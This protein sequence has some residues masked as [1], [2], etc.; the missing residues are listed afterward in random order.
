MAILTG[1]CKWVLQSGDAAYAMAVTDDGL[2]VHSHWGRCLPRLE[3]YPTPV[4]QPPFPCE[5]PFQLTPQELP[6]GE[7]SASDERGI[8][9]MTADGRI[10]GLILRFTDAA[11]AGDTLTITLTDTA[12]HLRV[13]LTYAVLDQPGLFSRSVAVIN[14]GDR[15]FKITRLF[16]G[17]FNLPDTG[18]F[19]ITQL[20]GR[21]GD[22]FR[23]QRDPLP[24][25]T[26][27]RDSRRIITSHGGVPYFALDRVAPGLAASEETGALWFGTLDWSGNW[28]LI[29]ERTRDDRAIVHLGL[30]DH[31]FA[32]D[33]QPGERFDAPRIVFGYTEGGFGAMSRSF[34]DLIRDT[35]APRKP[36]VPPVVYNSWYATT[37]HVDEAGQTALADKAAAMGVEMFVMDD[38][39]F[40]GRVDDTAGLGDWWPD[41]V[42]FP[43]GLGPLIAAVKA[44]GMGFGLWIEPEMV[45]PNS[46]LYAAHPDW[47][48]HFPGRDRTQM[49]NQLLLNLG[50]ADVQAYLIGIFDRLLTENAIDFVKWDMNR[51]ASEPGWPDHSRDQR[52]IWVRYVQGLRRVWQTLRDRHPRVI[53]ENCSSG[54]GRV[55][56]AMMGITEQSWASDNTFVPARLLIQEGYSQ[57]FP[58][59]TMAAWVTDSGDYSLDLRFHT[60][61]AGAL[62]VGGN[63]LRWSDAD[64]A[65]AAEHVARYKLLRGVIAQGDLYRIRSAHAYTVSAFAYVAKD[66]SEAVLFAFRMH[67]PRLGRDP[68]MGH[69]GIPGLGQG[70]LIP[71]PGL[72]PDAVYAT[73]APHP[74]LSGRALAQIGLRLALQDFGSTVLHLTRQG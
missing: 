69:D 34:H 3:D 28:R 26:I 64:L 13:L 4:L 14:D 30:N 7:G 16:S 36:Y 29:A 9:G 60:S 38:G 20:N 23:L 42:K 44:R 32:W 74:A 49:R 48:V 19:A 45:N 6:T 37:F 17:T 63:L 12:L 58:A 71:V 46:Q 25:G 59:N 31:D 33:L 40:Q 21:W 73:D 51:S 57:L 70:R 41:A 2:L 62:G 8:D 39:W 10:R 72:D 55:D 52:E 5:S 18:P 27:Q 22:E 35:V 11:I 54:A 1:E 15:V 61:M 67:E 43:R 53:W 68:N 47:V 66:K 56:L 50:R 65:R 24:F